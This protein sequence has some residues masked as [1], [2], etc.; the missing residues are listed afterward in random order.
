M[1]MLIWGFFALT[2]GEIPEY[3]T[4]TVRLRRF[5][6]CRA[7]DGRCTGTVYRLPYPPDEPTSNRR[8]LLSNLCY[9]KL[10]TRKTPKIPPNEHNNERERYR[11]RTGFITLRQSRERV[12]L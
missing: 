8:M 7:S 10:P 5:E 2:G 12:V 9:V 4:I 6:Q 3:E 1:I 11:R